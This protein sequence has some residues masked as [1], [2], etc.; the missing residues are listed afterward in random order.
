MLR[1]AY[2]FDANEFKTMKTTTLRSLFGAF[3]ILVSVAAI[4]I[5]Q[6]ITANLYGSVKDANGAAVPN[7]TVTIADPAKENLVVRTVQ[8]NE[9][10][11][12][13][14]PNLPVAIY[15]VTVEAANFKRS[16]NTE[17]K[18]DVGQRR[19]LDVTLE[20][21]NIAE[22]VT[23][24]ADA[25]AVEANSPQ[26]STTINGDQVRE[27]SLNN[28]NWV[29]LVTLAPGVSNDMNDSISVGTTDPQT[30]AVNLVSISVNGARSSQNT[31]TVD[32]ADIT[33][34]G[35]NLTI[36][37]YPS[38]DSIGEFLVLRSL[39]PA[40]SGR[41]GGGQI[42]VVTRSGSDKFHGG[43][44][45]FVRNE[46][47]N[48]NSP[49]Q[50]SL[51]NVP[52]ANREPN[53]KIKRQPFRYNN[54][55]W[56]IGGPVYFLKFGERDPGDGMFGRWDKTYFFFS[57]EFRSDIRYPVFTTTVPTQLQRNFQFTAPICVQASG[58]TC[59]SF[60]TGSPTAPVTLP[61]VNPVSAAYVQYVYN[62][63][64]LPNGGATAPN[65][66]TTGIR[67]V[68]EF[69]Q[70]IVKIDHS[71]TE[72]LASNYRYQRDEI[73]TI[74][75]NSLFSSG[76]GLPGVPTTSTQS[77]GRAH[78]FQTIYT[79]SPKL[80]A[81][82][83]YTYGYGAIL[84]ENVGLLAKNRSPINLNLPY[85]VTRDRIPSISGNGFT[86]LA[87]Y[88]PLENFSYKSS[89]GGNVTWILGNHTS[90]YGLVWTKARKN[91][92]NLSGSN[93]G[94]FSA[95]RVPGATS[96][97]VIA[98]GGN[99]TQQ[100]W[101]NFLIGTNATLNQAAFDY[102]ADLRQ[103]NFEAYAQDEWK[104]R[105]NLTLYMGVRYS[106]FGS[107]YD[108]NGRLSNFVPSLY[109]R[110]NAP[111]VEGD[112][113]RVPG[114][115]NYCNGLI[116]NSNGNASF[117][118]CTPTVSPWGKYVIDAPKNDFAPRVGLAWDPFSDGKIALRTG[119]GIYHEQVL[120]AT[121]LN[122]IIQNPPF[123]QNC[124]ISGISIANPPSNCNLIAS[125]LVSNLR[126]VDP[127][128]KTPFMQ[129]WSLDYQ[130]RLTR[131][132]LVTAGYFG[133][134]GTNLIG[135]FEMNLLAPGQA[136]NSLC[137]PIGNT[138]TPTVPCQQ[139]NQAFF[140]TTGAGGEQ[141][142]DQIR[143]YR[144]Y[145]SITMIQPRYNS[146][147][148][149]LQIS[150]QQR[151]SGASQFNVAYTWAK[152]LTDNPNDR[153]AAPQNSYDIGAE[154]A[155]A[156]L[157]R[158]HIFTANWIYELPWFTDQKGFIG[159]VLGGWQASGVATFQT[160]LGFTPTVSGFDPA[161]LG[162]IPPPLTV[163]RAN[164]TCDPNSGG[165][166]TVQQWF[167]TSCF[168][169]VPVNNNSPNPPEIGDAS[170]G[171]IEGPGTKRVDFTMAKNIRFGER[172][173]LQLRGEAFNVF[174][175]TNPRGLSTVVWNQL[176]APIS[177]GGTC[178]P[179]T[180]TCSTFGQV[181]SFRDPRVIQLG[182]KFNF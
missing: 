79:I 45:E 64:P 166:Q 21:G 73:P 76:T 120:N 15:T 78:T 127:N 178:N 25:V 181:T 11:I 44:Y 140:I 149:S 138:T 33:D 139:P 46:K 50:N 105:D 95:F 74:D 174:N 126:A 133:S 136:R 2:R 38:V 112:G 157:D 122:I 165:A 77:P 83:R 32:G 9:E 13:S 5:A 129:H 143:P 171:M 177:A 8:T 12:F 90:K 128:W 145:R 88:G 85:T 170:R 114:T 125:N 99:L 106:F 4:S 173:R 160:G 34:R 86:A 172:Y 72:K 24:E 43:L 87:G 48:A 53:G 147:Y 31:F 117:P 65:T 61:N 116:V 59:T 17:V 169:I 42:N 182:I 62:N 36:Q 91:E 124:S 30:G 20:A 146:N 168:Q 49:A 57:Q 141:I 47:L 75:A 101:A 110:A 131:K 29:Q 98:T 6:D 93:E 27:L 56:N 107:P 92:N 37:A 69:R 97:T 68:A 89:I 109:N 51:T 63:L 121:F 161:G 153:S 163:A 154:K 39:Y 60:I 40:E 81:E 111:L 70:E 28:R 16:V 14:A 100:Q 84:S 155:R 115:G 96:D 58:T 156:A 150:G 175:W 67:N 118:N 26:A 123:Q 55:G 159:K 144:G 167:N 94:A 52:A 151:F 142:L 113:D 102:E 80:I 134:K 152:N 148:H 137:A 54:Y 176:T 164:A 108:K 41:S 1:L 35:S 71:F 7:A 180:Q 162:L 103:E 179:T 3:L 19:D 18:L 135:G 132:T 10:G 23:V 130:H 22:V 82:G 158:R 66:L 104:M 119:Y